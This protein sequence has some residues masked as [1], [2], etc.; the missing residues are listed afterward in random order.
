M[1]VKSIWQKL[2]ESL[3]LDDSTAVDV[4]SRRRFIKGAAGLAA[5]AAI[6]V[7]ASGALQ[8]LSPAEKADLVTKIESG[9]VIENITFVLDK[10]ITL[11]NVSNVLIRNCRFIASPDFVGLEMIYIDAGCEGLTIRDSV[12]E[13]T[14]VGQ[15]D[16]VV[17]RFSGFDRHLAN[18]SV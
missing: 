7:G 4:E 16:Q 13:A 17:M 12:F 3:Q 14:S 18:F 1:I 15:N 8:L 6:P 9:S 11:K 2:K 5:I 10:P